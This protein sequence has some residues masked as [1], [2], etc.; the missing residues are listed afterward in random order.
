VVTSNLI[1]DVEQ[2]HFGAALLQHVRQGHV[3]SVLAAA[4]EVKAGTAGAGLGLA[5]V[6]EIM[7][8]H[9][10]SITTEENPGGGMVFTLRFNTV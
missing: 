8:A 6:A 4:L 1:I 2:Q 5:I 10:G 9:H 7:R 3:E